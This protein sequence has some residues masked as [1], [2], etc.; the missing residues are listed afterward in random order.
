VAFILNF[1]VDGPDMRVF[2]TESKYFIRMMIG[3]DPYEEITYFS[4]ISLEISVT[5]GGYELCFWLSS[6]N[7]GGLE[8]CHWNG[9]ETGFIGQPERGVILQA[10]LLAIRILID[11]TVPGRVFVLAMWADMPSAA[12]QKYLDVNRVFEE[13]GYAVTECDPKYGVRSWLMEL[14][15]IA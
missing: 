6:E 13:M 3:F 1:G 9:A 5:V 10:I 11:K 8:E 4:T 2:S 14:P 7:A 15:T 12:I